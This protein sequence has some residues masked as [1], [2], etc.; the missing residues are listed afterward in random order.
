MR[1][2][3]V[4]QAGRYCD[5]GHRQRLVPRLR[6]NYP[7]VQWL[8]ATNSD[9]L[10]VSES[11]ESRNGLAGGSG[12]E[13]PGSLRSDWAPGL[14]LAQG[15]PGA[16]APACKLAHGAIRSSSLGPSRRALECVHDVEIRG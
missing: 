10:A 5:D 14:P 4:R 1:R 16:G 12:S 13:L 15:P 11:Q 9:D 2:A 7:T 6:D 3:G 8:K